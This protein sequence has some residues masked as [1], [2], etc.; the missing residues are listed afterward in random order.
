M[1]DKIHA[2]DKAQGVLET[3]VDGLEKSEGFL[4]K[5]VEEFRGKVEAIQSDM[6]RIKVDVAKITV[7]V[8]IV[9]IIAT[10]V[11]VWA[12]TKGKEEK[13]AAR[14]IHQTEVRDVV[15]R[16]GTPGPWHLD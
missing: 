7:I 3:R 15:G 6:G 4:W 11:I 2:M 8:G 1:T 13:H 5:A 9:Q 12:L 14:Q 10:G 16:A